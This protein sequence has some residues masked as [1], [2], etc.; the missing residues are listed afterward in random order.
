MEHKIYCIDTIWL[1]EKYCNKLVLG[2]H[3]CPS[4]AGLPYTYWYRTSSRKWGTVLMECDEIVLWDSCLPSVVL[5]C[6]IVQLSMANSDKMR[7][8]PLPIHFLVSDNLCYY[9]ACLQH[10][11]HSLH[12]ERGVVETIHVPALA[13]AATNLLFSQNNTPSSRGA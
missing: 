10:D 8:F 2:E 3:H 4:Y 11:T 9:I 5:Q 12:V 1:L 13:D 7:T 6:S